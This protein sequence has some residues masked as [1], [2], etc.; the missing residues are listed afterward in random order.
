MDG[1]KAPNRRGNGF[2]QHA[3][4]RDTRLAAII[5]DLVGAVEA[6][7]VKHRVTRDELSVAMCFA[8]DVGLSTDDRRN[9]WALL[10]D[11]TGLTDLIEKIGVDRPMGATAQTMLGPFYRDGAP[12]KASG[13]TISIDG[14]GVPLSFVAHV[15]DLDG[16][17]VPGAT[18]DVWQANGD[19]TFENQNPDSQPDY[20]LRGR[21]VTDAQGVVTFRTVRPAGYSLPAD[22][23][24]AALLRALDLSLVRPAHIQ[25]RVAATGFQ[26][27]VTHVFDKSDP[28]IG[29]DPLWCAAPDLLADFGDKTTG[30]TF[31]L[32]RARPDHHRR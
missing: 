4:T 28:Q 27:L 6:V 13:D 7:V 22:G 21:F 11:A 17:P 32:A 23:P 5:A 15:T 30:F 14:I 3:A 8:T 26:T 31:K 9:E 2:A 12:R 25:F 10:S 16:D 18:V 1:G 24:V 29:A 19:G 20:N